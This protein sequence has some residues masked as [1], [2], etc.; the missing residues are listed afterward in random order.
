MAVDGGLIDDDHRHLI[1][2]IN[3]FS[4][5]R[6]RGRGALAQA[7]DCLNALK[8]YAETHFTREERLQRLVNYPEHGRQQDEHRE[9]MAALDGMIW[10]AQRTL[11]EAD[12]ADIVEELGTLLRRWLLNHIIKLDLRM[13]PYAAAMNRHAADL[14]P[15]SAV[16]R[17]R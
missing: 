11:S 7:V 15:L 2:I 9:L 3:S 13:K 8:F 10:R 16:R 12:A 5:H 1:D 4:Y 17:V 14:L 6:A